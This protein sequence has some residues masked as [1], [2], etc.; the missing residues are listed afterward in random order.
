MAV[1]NTMFQNA[2]K[3]EIRKVEVLTSHS[4]HTGAGFKHFP[5]LFGPFLQKN[6]G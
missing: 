3:N 6:V 4:L 1:F 2:S 5:I